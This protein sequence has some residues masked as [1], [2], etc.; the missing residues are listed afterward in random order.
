MNITGLKMQ[1]K[2][3]VVM[4]SFC[5]SAVHKQ[6]TYHV[7]E[8]PGPGAATTLSPGVKPDASPSPTATTSPTP[9]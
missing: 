4:Y 5:S 1:V 3:V 8:G 7:P 6:R 9:I 2:H